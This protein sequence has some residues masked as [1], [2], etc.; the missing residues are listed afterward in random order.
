MNDT[1]F[2]TPPPVPPPANPPAASRL[3]ALGSSMLVRMVVLGILILLSLIPLSM[4]SSVLGER[5]ARRNEAVAGITA[6]WGEAQTVCGP[7]LVVPYHYKVRTPRLAAPGSPVATLPVEETL[8]GYACFLPQDL[9]ITGRLAPNVLHRGIY[10]AVVYGGDLELSGKF[11]P[12]AFDDWHIAPADVLWDDAVLTLGI[13]DLRGAKETVSLAWND[14]TR[15]MVPGSKLDGF[16][17]GIHAR[18]GAGAVSATSTA[19]TFSLKLTLNGS[20]GIRFAPLGEQTRVT[21]KS[22]WADPSFAGAFLP[23]ERHVDAGGFEATWKVS[24]YGRSLPQQWLSQDAARA[25]GPTSIAASLFG[26]DLIDV[27]D[28]YRYVERSIK[29]G[30]LFVVLVFTAFFLFEVLARIRVHPFQYTLVGLALCLFYL[31]LLSLSEVMPFG[32]AYLIGSAAATLLIAGYSGAVLKRL[33]R[34][35]LVALELVLIYGF[36][37]VILRLQDLSLILGTLGLFAA[38][39]TVMYVT[40]NIDWYARDRAPQP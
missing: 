10:Q 16:A 38:L 29:Y 32:S 15:R 14:C 9:D 40:R 37:F 6:T 28:T 3:A 25:L 7:V 39:A 35:L 34:A 8:T 27:V 2:P 5:L 30:I 36:L 17:S 31:A 13:T 24:Y 12:L 26:V 19:A 21:L 4:I 11:A 18:L 33:S 20:T 22:A 1:A 23:A